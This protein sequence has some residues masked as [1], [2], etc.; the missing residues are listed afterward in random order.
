[1]QTI[2]LSQLWVIT[3]YAASCGTSI[4]DDVV[5]VVEAEATAALQERRDAQEKN[6]TL[7]SLYYEKTTLESFIVEARS[8]ARDA[9]YASATY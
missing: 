9:G 2:P 5:Y 6:T 3:N 8:E 4:C 1:M 7:G